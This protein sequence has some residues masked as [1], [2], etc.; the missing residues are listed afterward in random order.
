[1]FLTYL[2]A[3]CGLAYSVLDLR[4]ACPI[5]PSDVTR[6][7]KC[8]YLSHGCSLHFNIAFKVCSSFKIQLFVS[9]V[10][11]AGKEN[12]MLQS[13]AQYY[14]NSF[15]DSK[16]KK[17][18]VWLFIIQYDMPHYSPL[19][20]WIWPPHAWFMYSTQS[21]WSQLNWP[22]SAFMQFTQRERCRFFFFLGIKYLSVVLC[23]SGQL[24]FWFCGN[25]RRPQAT[26]SSYDNRFFCLTTVFFLFCFFFSFCSSWKKKVIVLWFTA[27][28]LYSRLSSWLV[29]LGSDLFSR[30]GIPPTPGVELP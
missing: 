12:K 25:C 15:Q 22:R 1:M 20:L 4:G 2:K 28:Q 21:G 11:I 9:H 8:M 7:L 14:G 29:S 5:I 19:G 17:N 23:S 26:D 30:L 16:K 18:C 24:S 13:A 3:A 27:S 6:E 10:D